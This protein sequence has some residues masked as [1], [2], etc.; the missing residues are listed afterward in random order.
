MSEEFFSDGVS[1]ITVIGGTVR[2]D[3][4]TYSPTEQNE[5]G[6]P[7]IVF[8]QRVIMSLEGFMETAGM[9]NE[10]VQTLAKRGVVRPKGDVAPASPDQAGKPVAP[11]PSASTPSLQFTRPFP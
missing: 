2:L 4:G 6:K 11:A 3:F 9:I 8:R 1:G 10:V 7:S 5:S